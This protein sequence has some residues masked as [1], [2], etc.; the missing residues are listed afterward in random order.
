M[1][2][3]LLTILLLTCGAQAG[4]DESPWRLG[5]ALGYGE[6]SNPLAQSDDVPVVIDLDIAWFGKRFFFDNG[7]AGVTL[8]DNALATIS[9]VAR[10]NSDRV[11]FGRTNTRLVNVSLTG[12][13]LAAA[14]ELS[15][16]DRDY[17]LEPGIELLMAGDWGHLQ[18]SLHHD[19]SGTHDGYSLSAEFGRGLRYG[20][21]YV[22]P[23][24]RLTYKSR[25]LN[26]YYWGVRAAE[27]SPALPAYRAGDGI[28]LHGGMRAS[29][30]LSRNTAL[31][32]GLQYERLNDAVAASPI[33]VDDHVLGYFAGVSW[34]R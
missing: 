34:R 4:A 9:L 33:V 31:S 13:V 10:V 26:D 30:Y 24:L 17:A 18:A 3:A 2:R 29:Y 23:S 7:D 16:P 19:I 5:V 25:A 15:I 32:V 28:N 27:S 12:E 21:W 22:E 11:F 6:R 1:I 20:R 8:V 14:E